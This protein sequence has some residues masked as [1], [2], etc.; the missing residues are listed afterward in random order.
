MNLKGYYII[1]NREK[2]YFDK[3]YKYNWLDNEYIYEFKNEKYLYAICLGRD[4]D[5]FEEEK[6]YRCGIFDLYK[7][8]KVRSIAYDILYNKM[9][10]CVG[11]LWKK[12]GNIYNIIY[13]K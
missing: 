11:R 1:K 10:R 9:K 6:M 2:L 8:W 7:R 12:N 4:E 13:K 5:L 3:K